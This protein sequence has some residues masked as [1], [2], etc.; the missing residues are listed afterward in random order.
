MAIES[1]RAANGS[2][3][4][5]RD[6]ALE[7]DIDWTAVEAS[8]EFRELVARRR[9]FVIG[10]TA[11]FLPLFLA[12]VVLMTYGKGV[13]ATQVIGSITLGWLV[14]AVEIVM[15]WVITYLYLRRSD[16]VFTPLEERAARRAIDIG[17][18]GRFARS[19]EEPG[20]AVR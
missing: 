2:P 12:Y 9:R 3:A 14:G 10:A 15:A 19:T 6:P 5:T 11:V 16:R 8:P 1:T 13:M 20:R 7:R 4:E 17:R 18:E